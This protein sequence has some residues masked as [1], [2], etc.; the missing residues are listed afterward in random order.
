MPSQTQHFLFRGPT[1][2]GGKDSFTGTLLPYNARC[3]SSARSKG[4][5]AR[6]RNFQSE[7]HQWAQQTLFT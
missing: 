3:S 5:T 6:S 1:G 4:P 7:Q 2:N